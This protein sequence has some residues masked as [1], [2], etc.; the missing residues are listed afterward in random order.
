MISKDVLED[1]A[2]S[3][4]EEI[5]REKVIWRE[6]M[7]RVEDSL[8]HEE[9]TVI[10]GVRRAGKTFVLFHMLQKHGGIYLNFEDDRLYDFDIG[11]FEKVLDMAQEPKNPIIYLDEVQ[12][13]A[14][15]EKFAHRIHRKVKLF[16]TGSNSGLL[17]PSSSRSSCGSLAKER[18]GL[19]FWI[20][21]RPE[22]FP[23]SS[24]VGIHP[25]LASTSTG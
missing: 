9:V 12:H 14:G 11:D 3:W 25:W 23:E 19:R 15:W 20:T 2:E 5:A 1:V 16:V 6:V 18:E 7:A 13:V 17:S 10:R 22:A 4:A 21:W 8:R 24:S